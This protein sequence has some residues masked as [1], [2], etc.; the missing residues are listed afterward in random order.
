MGFSVNTPQAQLAEI[1]AEL[2]NLKAEVTTLRVEVKELNTKSSA[3]VR[4]QCTKMTPNEIS[5]S[6]LPCEIHK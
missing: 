4:A 6:G 2:L 5:L 3:V 1:K